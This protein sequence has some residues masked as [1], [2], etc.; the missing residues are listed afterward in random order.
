VSD[1]QTGITVTLKAGVGFEAPW[2]VVHAADTRDALDQI[3]TGDFATLAERTVAAAEFFRAAHN[4]KK[5]LSSNE[6]AEAPA[7]GG[8]SW[9]QQGSQQSAPAVEGG[10]GKSCVHGAMTFRSGISKKTNKPYSAWFCPTPQ[11]TPNQCAP[12]FG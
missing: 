7:Q 4:V 3:N 5:G 1:N 6:A 12:V 8:P 9:S 2:I 11:G 10:G